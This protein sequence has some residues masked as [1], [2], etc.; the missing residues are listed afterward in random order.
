[1]KSSREMIQYLPC[2]WN[3]QETPNR[4]LSSIPIYFGFV[5]VYDKMEN[6]F[7]QAQTL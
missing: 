3:V 5:T 1:M 4:Y 2:F 7:R 6:L